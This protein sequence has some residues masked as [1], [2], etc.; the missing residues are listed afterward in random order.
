MSKVE[1]KEVQE[2][3]GFSVVKKVP[4]RAAL[5][6]DLKPNTILVFHGKEGHE[7][8][9]EIFTPNPNG[10]KTLPA[11]KMASTKFSGNAEKVDNAYATLLFWAL[12]EG[13]TLGTPTREIYT[14][15][16][17]SQSPPEVEVEVQAPLQ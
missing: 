5:T 10:D 2:V 7:M 15:V 9:V 13:K 6:G 17:A 14:K 1:V 3:R 4:N 11:A 12:K 8:V 16:D